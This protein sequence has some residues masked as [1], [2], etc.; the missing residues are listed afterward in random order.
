VVEKSVKKQGKEIPFSFFGKELWNLW[1][2]NG[3]FTQAFPY[4]HTVCDMGKCGLSTYPQ[5]LLVL[6][7]DL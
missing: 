7:L 4:G 3:L 1:K 6:V 5:T 2:R